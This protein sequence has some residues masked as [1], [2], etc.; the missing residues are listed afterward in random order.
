VS[1]IILT[2]VTADG[3]PIIAPAP[4]VVEGYNGCFNGWRFVVTAGAQ[5]FHDM[6]L[7]NN[8]RIQGG[9]RRLMCAGTIPDTDLMELSVVDKDNFTGMF[10]GT[11]PHGMNP[12]L[13]DL[14]LTVGVDVLEIF[15]Y[16]R[17]H[18]ACEADK[19]QRYDFEFRSAKFLPAGLYLRAMYNS[20]GS[21]DLVLLGDYKWYEA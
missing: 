11:D 5:N 12:T 17:D 2:P 19:N 1:T 4:T 7:T 9:W 6:L 8:I 18:Y 3:D 10:D 13:I 21:T 16:V 14:D 20:T 15:K